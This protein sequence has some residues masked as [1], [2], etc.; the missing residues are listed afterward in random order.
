MAST[1]IRAPDLV[2]VQLSEHF[3]LSELIDSQTAVRQ[4]I[5]NIPSPEQLANLRLLAARLEQVRR[6]LGGLPI[7][8]SS[9]FRSPALNR[10]V[11]GAPNSAHLDGLA[12]D[13]ACARFG[14]PLAICK[15]LVEADIAFDQV[16]YE[17][18]WVHLGI[19][20]GRQ[21][22]QV[23]TAKFTPDGVVY[24]KGLP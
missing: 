18:T 9:G 3:A 15:A 24:S 1:T 10:A 13:F 21:R 20:P 22:H 5:A 12:A 23:L 16:I 8:V 7:T 4:G 17:G 19:A 2:D 6:L 14:T 11:G